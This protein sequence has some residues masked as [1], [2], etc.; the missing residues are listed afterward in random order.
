MHVLVALLTM[1]TK[2]AYSIVRNETRNTNARGD[3]QIIIKLKISQC[4]SIRT[5]LPGKIA[6]SYPLPFYILYT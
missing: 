5:S 3:I 2:D 6:T 1:F 4:T